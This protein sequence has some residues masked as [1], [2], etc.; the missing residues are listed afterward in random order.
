VEPKPRAVR[1]IIDSERFA[2]TTL[3]AA[4]VPWGFSMC[5]VNNKPYSGNTIEFSSVHVGQFFQ[6][7]DNSKVSV[8]QVA[9]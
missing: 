5:H 2:P 6:I 1:P 8:E 3:S 7:K 9:S 4:V